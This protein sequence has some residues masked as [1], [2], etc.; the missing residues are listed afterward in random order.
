VACANRGLIVMAQRQFVGNTT[1][2]PSKFGTPTD[3]DADG[4]HNDFFQGSDAAADTSQMP[5]ALV[6]ATN[7]IQEN[8]IVYAVEAYHIPSTIAF[9]GI[10]APDIMYSRAFF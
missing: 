2:Q 10:F 5:A 6:D 1:I 7:G 8:E 9:E 3:L 4:N